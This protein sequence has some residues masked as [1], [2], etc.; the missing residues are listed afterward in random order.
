MTRRFDY[1]DRVIKESMRIFPVVPLVGRHVSEDTVLCDKLIP[2]G[3]ILL[4]NFYSAH[5]DPRFWENPMTFDPDRFLLERSKGRHPHC[6]LPFSAGPRDCIGKR[7]AMLQM[8]TLLATTL[9]AYRLL[10]ANDGIADPSQMPL[11][12]DITLHQT[13]GTKVKFV[14]RA[15]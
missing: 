6:Y 9:R 13:G 1:L 12:W 14:P 5:R 15:H 4:V 8:K 11:S 10:P 3:T 2:A 7:Y